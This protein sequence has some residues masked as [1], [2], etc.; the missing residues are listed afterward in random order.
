LVI[1]NIVYALAL[2]GKHLKSPFY[3]TFK[4]DGFGFP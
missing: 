1:C 4:C 2:E 3:L